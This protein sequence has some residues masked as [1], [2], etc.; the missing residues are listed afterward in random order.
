MT[1][2]GEKLARAAWLRC[3][4]GIILNKQIYAKAVSEAVK[5]GGPAARQA[6]DRH[7]ARIAAD[8]PTIIRPKLPQKRKPTKR[9]PVEFL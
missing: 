2:D 3:G 9:K 5:K 4:K 6:F 1:A 7:L 8:T